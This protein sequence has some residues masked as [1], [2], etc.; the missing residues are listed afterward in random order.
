MRSKFLG[1]TSGELESEM[2]AP[3]PFVI[4]RPAPSWT[5]NFALQKLGPE[6][7]QLQSR[8]GEFLA[9]LQVYG[10]RHFLPNL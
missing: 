3:V 1:N 6:L 10:Y 5:V 4:G 2:G 7:D 9:V 8:N